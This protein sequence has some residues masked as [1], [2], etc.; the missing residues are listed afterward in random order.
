MYTVSATS[1]VT[2]GQ[3]FIEWTDIELLEGLVQKQLAAW[4]EF[5]R[6]YSQMLCAVIARIVRRFSRTT[7]SED[8]RE[9][10]SILCLSLIQDKRRLESFQH[11]R[12]TKLA[13]WLSMLAIHA[14]YD[15]L[16]TL[17]RKPTG[18]TIDNLADI[19]SSCPIPDE[20]CIQQQQ[21]ALVAS[22]LSDLAEKDRTFMLLYFGRG[23]TPEEVAKEM[24]I[25]VKTVYTKK[26]KLRGRLE[27][28]LTQ[29]RTAA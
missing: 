26:H 22:L 5:N 18:I 11:D 7:S 20:L 19:A 8:A 3:S 29:Y 4:T 9:I 15:Y 25:S 10:Y 2:T 12:G 24:G 28:M 6:R 13:S 21:N 17:R 27:S 16:R 1:E 14:T 23:L